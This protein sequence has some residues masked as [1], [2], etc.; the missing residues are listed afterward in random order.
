LEEWLVLYAHLLS[1]HR[2]TGIKAFSRTAFERQMAV[3]GLVMFRAT[4][5]NAVLG[6]HLWY[7]QG[8]VAYGHLGATNA[9]GYELMAS[10]ALYW[11]AIEQ[12]RPIVRWLD[13]GNAPGLVEPDKSNGLLRFKS[14]WATDVRQVYL[15]GKILNQRRYAELA[16][17]SR[18]SPA[19]F[20]P[21]YRSERHERAA[22]ASTLVG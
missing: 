17:I 3:P 22:P 20:F 21:A 15:C 13:L 6:I 14:G 11:Y 18:T 2:I 7:V 4:S 19:T 9:Q 10:Y 16:E 8:D 12:L 1:R 5:G